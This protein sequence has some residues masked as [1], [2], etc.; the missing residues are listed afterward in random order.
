[1]IVSTRSLRRAGIGAGLALA[2]ILPNAAVATAAPVATA[3]ATSTAAVSA[4]TRHAAV[5]A[6]R[7]ALT[8]AAHD[9]QAA[10][11]AA[12]TAFNQDPTVVL[13]R[14]QRLAVISTSTDP[15]LILAANQAYAASVS[16]AVETRTAAFDTARTL[17]FA[18]VDA[19]WA[20]YDL[21]VNP[22]NALARNAYRAAMRSANYE[23]RTHVAAA[24][25]AF[26]TSTAAAHA[27]LR[28]SINSAIATYEA[29]GRTP[30]DLTAFVAA[31]KAGRTAFAT[32]P[33][34]VAARAARH[35]ALRN[36]WTRYAADVRAAR[37]AFHKATGHWPHSTRV[38]IPNV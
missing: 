35:T 11:T 28:A 33:A 8:K 1:M 10:V 20:A 13:A 38:V 34:V 25:K 23:L 17:R 18:A 26:R 29:S 4:S 3:S 12:R 32:D 14:S 31:L 24:H 5:V 2:L 36:A 9:Y 22:A 7:A 19:A 16:G 30:A 21:V 37:I 15:V 6:L 27:Q